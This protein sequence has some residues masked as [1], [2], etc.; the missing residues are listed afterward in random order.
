MYSIKNTEENFKTL[1]EVIEE[2][3]LI[4]YRKVL[5][6]IENCRI[7]EEDSTGIIIEM[8]LIEHHKLRLR[9]DQ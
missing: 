8:N 5:Y 3:K 4:I 9:Y 2:I 1:E 7:I 6:M